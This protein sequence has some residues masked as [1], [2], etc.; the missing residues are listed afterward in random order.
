MQGNAMRRACRGSSVCLGLLG[1]RAAV[2]AGVA[3]GAPRT[4]LDGR[5]SAA[6][7]PPLCRLWFPSG[8]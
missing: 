8:P 3:W 4:D 1:G 6:T 5:H 7:L 2:E